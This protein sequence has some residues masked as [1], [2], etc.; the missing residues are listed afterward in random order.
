MKEY[1]LTFVQSG[2]RLFVGTSELCCGQQ[3]FQT[4]RMLGIHH[5]V[6]PCDL[7]SDSNFRPPAKLSTSRQNSYT[8]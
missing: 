8:N 1:A 7:V 3:I 6:L 4:D 2:H 5:V